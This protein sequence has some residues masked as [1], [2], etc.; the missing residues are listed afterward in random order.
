MDKRE[1]ERFLRESN[2]F[3]KVKAFAE[4]SSRHTSPGPE[5]LGSYIDLDFAQSKAPR[6][7]SQRNISPLR[8]SFFP[9]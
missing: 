2:F 1:A 5:R 3:F 4:C 7:F 6:R 8:K 9:A